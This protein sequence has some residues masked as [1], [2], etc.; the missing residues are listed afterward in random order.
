MQQ[1]SH[2]Q[3]IALETLAQDFGTPLYVYDGEKIVQQIQ[4]LQTAFA[5][6]PLRIKYAT[7][8]LSSL[9]VLR[10][11]RKADRKSVV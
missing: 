10:L 4:S 1:P 8:A 5:A 6:V 11:I 3:G 9:S 7:K 2:I